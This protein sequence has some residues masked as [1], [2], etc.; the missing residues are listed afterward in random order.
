MQENVTIAAYEEAIAKI[1]QEVLQEDSVPATD[2][3][4]FDAGGTSL[5]LIRAKALLNERFAVEVRGC[6]LFKYTTIEKLAA[7]IAEIRSS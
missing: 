1:W 4:F 6:D 2:V 3:N 7:H 5:A